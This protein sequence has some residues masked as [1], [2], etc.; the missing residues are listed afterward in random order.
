MYIRPAKSVAK[1]MEKARRLGFSP[2]K[3]QPKYITGGTL[4]DYQKEGMK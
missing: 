3:G 4:M 1:K 2:L